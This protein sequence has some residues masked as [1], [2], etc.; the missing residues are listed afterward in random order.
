[1]AQAL[2]DAQARRSQYVF[3]REVSQT[4]GVIRAIFIPVPLRV[5]VTGKLRRSLIALWFAVGGDSAHRG[6]NLSNLLLARAAARAKEFCR[7]VEAL[8]A[9]RGRIRCACCSWKSLA[10]LRRR[11]PRLG[12][13][14]ILIVWLKHQGSLG[15]A[16]LLSTLRID[17]SRWGWTVLIGPVHRP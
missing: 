5:Y 11:G 6:V 9:S 8:G 7:S 13:A 4:L 12:L 17:S 10:L 2:D 16:G 3:Q 1:V 14:L 15:A